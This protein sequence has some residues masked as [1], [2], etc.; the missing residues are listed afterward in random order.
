MADE[1][2][3][4]A[5]S[6]SS[7]VQEGIEKVQAATNLDE[8]K[9]VRGQYAGGDSVLAKS[10]KAIG[11]L[12]TDQKKESGKLMGKLRADFGRAYDAKEV[13]LKAQEEARQLAAETVDMTQPV[14]R[15]PLGAR[16]PLPKL[17][18]DVQDFFVSMGWQIAEGPEVETEWHDF[19]ALN[20]GPDHPAR[21]MQDTFYIK[22]NQAK[23]SAGFVGSNMVMR[24]HTSPVQARAMLDRGVPLYIACP[25]RVYR[26]DE[27]DA[28]HTPG[29]PPVRG[30]GCG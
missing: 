19:D 2:A 16:H 9:A 15:H 6:V 12:P 10:S 30:P 21:Q 14:R 29:L 11:S 26:T 5:D 18:E 13:E 22:G 1:F 20:F 28:T 8:L 17:L 23:D 24:T 7:A 25:G 3:F 27:L 4:D